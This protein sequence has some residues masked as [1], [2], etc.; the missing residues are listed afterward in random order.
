MNKRARNNGHRGWVRSIYR[1]AKGIRDGTHVPVVTLANIG[2]IADICRRRRADGTVEPH[3][4]SWLW[5]L[6]APFHSVRMRWIDLQARGELTPELADELQVEMYE[7]AY[8]VLGESRS[9]RPV[10]ALT[11]YEKGRLRMDRPQAVGMSNFIIG[12]SAGR[13]DPSP[14]IGTRIEVSTVE[15]D[16]GTDIA[17]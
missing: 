6:Y 15:R 16:P 5:P 11:M 17:P 4:E 8:A 1:H 14:P 9:H 13:F 3:E 12:Q 10:R 2:S 7:A